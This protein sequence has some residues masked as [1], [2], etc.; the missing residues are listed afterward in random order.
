MGA[1][2]ATTAPREIVPHNCIVD[3]VRQFVFTATISEVQLCGVGIN[4]STRGNEDPVIHLA[5]FG[6][7]DS[8][9][10]VSMRTSALRVMWNLNKPRVIA[11]FDAHVMVLRCL[12]HFCVAYFRGLI[13]WTVLEDYII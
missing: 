1:A 13:A 4:L 9:Y 10:A 7:D 11:G 5:V 6:P 2:C 3:D 12:Q 8:S